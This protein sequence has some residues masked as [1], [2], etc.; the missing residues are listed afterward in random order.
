MQMMDDFRMPKEYMKTYWCR[1]LKSKKNNSDKIIL[2]CTTPNV[3]D[4][5]TATLKFDLKPRPM[6]NPIPS[7]SNKCYHLK[8]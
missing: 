1:C 8:I 7:S 3:K 4:F 6:Y 2:D 5:D